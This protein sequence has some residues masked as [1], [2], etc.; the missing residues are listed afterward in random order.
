MADDITIGEIGRRLDVISLQVSQLVGR[1][2]FEVRLTAIT[3]DI[4]ELRGR[5]TVA[6]SRRWQATLAVI[7]S[8]AFPLILAYLSQG[9]HG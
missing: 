9:I 1:P 5:L 6:E 2:E 8:V 3:E 4:A 7:T